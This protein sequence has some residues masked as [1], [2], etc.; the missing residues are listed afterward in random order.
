MSGQPIVDLAA[1]RPPRSNDAAHPSP[2]S[3]LAA[4]IKGLIDAGERDAARGRFGALVALLV[5]AAVFFSTRA[6][7]LLPLA[8]ALNLSS[9]D[10]LS[11]TLTIGLVGGGLAVGCLAGIVASR[12]V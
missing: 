1:A 3:I 12:R 9:V 5:L 11:P 6:R 2:A 10:F 7:F 4:E 8:T